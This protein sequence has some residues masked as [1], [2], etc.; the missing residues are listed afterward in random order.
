MT[1]RE[2]DSEVA[3][4]STKPDLQ[5]QIIASFFYG[6]KSRLELTNLPRRLDLPK[7][8]ER[9]PGLVQRRRDRIGSFCLSFCADDRCLSF[10]LGFFD[11]EFSSLGILLC[12]LLLLDS[13]G[14]FFAESGDECA[15][16]QQAMTRIIRLVRS[17]IV[18]KDSRLSLIH[19]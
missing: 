12:D 3:N 15:S 11:D 7:R 10:L 9:I 6:E 1:L 18:G 19:I 8:H 17:R 14:E 4:I 16:W 2:P 5:E 13:C